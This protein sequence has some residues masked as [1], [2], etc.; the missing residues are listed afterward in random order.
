MAKNN[1]LFLIGLTTCLQAI[2]WN[3]HLE[4][5]TVYM[6]V[7]LCVP[8]DKVGFAKTPPKNIL[9]RQNLTPRRQA[10]PI[11]HTHSQNHVQKTESQ[12]AE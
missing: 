3:L 9:K 8:G 4:A 6:Q 5:L 11:T 7:C 12:S 1:F 10:S 2:T